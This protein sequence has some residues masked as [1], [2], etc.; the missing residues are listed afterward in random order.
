MKQQII[1]VIAAVL[2]FV[3][4]SGA[5]VIT[6]VDC[7]LMGLVC[8]VCSQTSMINLYHPGGYLTWPSFRECDGMGIHRFGGESAARGDFGR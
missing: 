3:P 4:S 1:L 7:D 5:Q 8:N 2:G 6:T